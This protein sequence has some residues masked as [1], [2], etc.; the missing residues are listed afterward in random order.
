MALNGHGGSHQIC[1]LLKVKRTC[2]RA[3][4]TARIDHLR[5]RLDRNPAT[6]Q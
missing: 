3:T 5:H 2:Q 6:Q 1:P 4:V